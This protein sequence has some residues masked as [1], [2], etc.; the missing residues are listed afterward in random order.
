MTR[1]C[2]TLLFF[3]VFLCKNVC[4][5]DAARILADSCMHPLAAL[6]GDEITVATPGGFLISKSAPRGKAVSARLV[7]SGKVWDCSSK[8]WM[9]L[10]VSNQGSS[11]VL[12]RTLIRSENV[13]SWSYSRGGAIIQPGET[14][15]VATLIW[16]EIPDADINRL[17]EALGELRS[18]PYAHQATPWMLIDASKINVVELEFYTDA[19]Q[20]E[21]ALSSLR[22][23][24]DFHLP[25]EAELK[26]DYIPSIDRFG[27]SR[28]AQ[29]PS[30]IKTAEDFQERRTSENALIEKRPSITN[31]NAYGGWTEGEPLKATGNFYTTKKEGKW[32]LVDP[33]GRLF[34]SMGITCLHYDLGWTRTPG[35][36]SELEKTPA[37]ELGPSELPGLHADLW[38]PY[39]ANLYRKYGTDWA[40]ENIRHSHRRLRSWGFNTLGNWTSADFYAMRQTPYTVAVHYQRMS[41]EGH[42]TMW[43]VTLPDVFHPEFEQRTL[44]RMH[45]EKITAADPWCIGYFIDNELAFPD[46]ISP[47]LRT[48]EAAASCFTRQEMMSRLG[49]KYGGIS[50]LNRAWKTGFT[51]WDEVRLPEGVRTADC[52]SDLDDFSRHYYHTYYRICRDAVREAAPG[53]LYLGDRIC[54]LKN[55]TALSICAEYADVVSINLYDYTP[56]I[57]DLPEGFDAPLLVGEFHFGTVTERGYWGGGLVTAT[58]LSQAAELFQWYVGSA[59]NHPNFVGVHWFQFFDQ[60][61]SGR[62]SD[63]ENHRIGFVDVTDTPYPEMIEASREIAEKMYLMRSKSVTPT[64]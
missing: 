54:F 12:V 7:P 19:S 44:D 64:K 42:E 63:G 61:L 28:T 2:A 24:V 51:H 39:T 10:N 11:P 62:R 45:E 37:D 43:E 58:D 34:W 30:K 1:F 56:N 26:S 20:V 21:V 53:K 46:D 60:P 52:A 14:G 41:L 32:W 55:H 35:I 31:R 27:Q 40:T 48:L 29:W 22:A 16:R 9:L 57:L 25:S 3:A 8:L 4:A 49:K 18:F 47:A 59:L 36:W 50:S 13:P 6:S 23:A 5:D 17:K 33:D 15:T 38:N